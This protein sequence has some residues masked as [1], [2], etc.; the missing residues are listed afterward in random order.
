MDDRKL[1]F[2]KSVV[3]NKRGKGFYWIFGSLSRVLDL[4][5]FSFLFLFIFGKMEGYIEVGWRI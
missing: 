1:L 5:G 4:G 3:E 2:G